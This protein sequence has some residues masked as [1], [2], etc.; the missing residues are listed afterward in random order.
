MNEMDSR[1][2]N[3]ERGS[4][5]ERIKNLNKR[6]RREKNKRNKDRLIQERERLKSGESNEWGPRELH[7]AFGGAYRRYRI[8]G[9]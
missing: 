1:R 3:N 5:N 8:N 2:N 6:I 9:V 4:I 7:G